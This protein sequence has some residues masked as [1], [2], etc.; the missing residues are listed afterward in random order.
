[1]TDDVKGT[2]VFNSFELHRDAT[3]DD[4][5]ANSDGAAS[6]ENEE[7]S[8]GTEAS[9]EAEGSKAAQ[10]TES[11]KFRHFVEAKAKETDRDNSK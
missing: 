2:G 9:G 3:A 1:M 5:G 7:A 6:A 10:V 4:S 8:G 11:E